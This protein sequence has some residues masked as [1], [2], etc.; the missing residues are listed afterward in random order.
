MPPRVYCS[1]F[2]PIHPVDVD[3]LTYLFSNPKNT[4]DDKPIY[5]DAVTGAS[6]SYGDIK[7]RTRSLAH[8]L[9]DLGVE[10]KDIVA[11]IS[12][13]SIDYA[14]TCY[15]I[16]G[17]GA[18]VS[19]VNAAYT[20]VELQSQLETSGAKYLI[21]HSALLDTAEKA[22]KFDPDIKVIQADGTPD[23]QGRP[24]AEF[25]ATKCPSSPLVSIRPEEASERLS[26]MCFSSGTTGRAKGVMT[27]HKNLVSNVQ[28]WLAQVPYEATG[29]QTTVT[30]LPF[31]H[32][33]GLTSFI[34]V[35]SMV[36]N[37]AVVLS[38]FEPERYMSS[39]QK[40][41]PE[42]V[43]LVPPVMLLLAKHPLVEK[44]DLGSLK[45]I[46]SAAAPLSVGLREAVEERFKK[47]YG[48]TVLGLQAWGM[49]ETS[50]LGS[51]VPPTRP[52]KRHTVGNI[53]PS[54]EFRVVD[55]E[56]MQDTET[57][58][59]GSSKPGE[60]WCRG[61]NVTKG[62]YRNEE[63]TK[64]GFA[65]DEDGKLWLRTG[66]I[67]LID[68]DGFIIIVDRIKEMIKY[69]GWQIIPSELE[70]KL[71]EHPD[72]ED[73]CVVGHW[74]EEQATELPVGFVVIT[75]K[76]K[77]TSEKAIVDGIHQWLNSQIA[78]HKRLRGG[79]FVVEAI[80]KS[81][82]GKIMRRQLKDILKA[83]SPKAESKL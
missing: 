56:T 10:P 43:S 37:T 44:Y 20:P 69:K 27:T 8:G 5:I 45:R 79:L 16:L 6:R 60:I 51:M 34:C 31:S 42:S 2:P 40:Y 58:T 70:G 1:S 72:V 39:I 32:I 80:P 41:R 74:V 77:T 61:P 28:Q 38:R 36:G 3:L 62:Y 55:P 65:S 48:T 81:A 17:C 53:A 63:A 71:L 66:D 29:D 4:P 68:K 75:Q 46:L 25:L 59:D 23:K 11:F 7:R 35:N 82:S 76:A 73:A 67:G 83:K 54:M 21:V 47:L 18:T 78:N 19:P 33:Y 14:I 57:D 9:R 12:P 26:F 22:V 50:P 30:F 15:G 49:T 24:T 64:T 13:N 52:D